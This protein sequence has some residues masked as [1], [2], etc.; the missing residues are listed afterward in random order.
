MNDRNTLL[1]T[2]ATGLVGAALRPRL[3]GD[4]LRV[5]TLGRD[6][7]RNDFVWDAASGEPPPAEALKGL[8]AVVNLAGSPIAER[9]SAA[10]KRDIRATRVN[11][12]L[13]LA[14]ALAALPVGDRPETF[15]SASGVSIYGIRRQE[16][17]LTEDSPL[18]PG[19]P[20]FLPAVSRDWEA[21]SDPAKQAGIRTVLLRMAP[22]LSAKGGMLRTVLPVFRAGLGGPVGDGRQRVCWIV[23]DDLVSLIRFALNTPTLA[24]PVNAVA[25]EIVTN[26]RFAELLGRAVGKRA[27]LR[28]PAGAVKLAFGEMAGETILSDVAPYPEKALRA[29][30]VFA[31]PT[32]EGALASLALK[33]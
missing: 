27:R 32:L 7:A 22:V 4:G 8:K 3:A 31:Y 2:G 25:P 26:E 19:S 17:R 16:T 29:G 12:T 24:G 30:F 10:R 6:P 14:S 21:A 18:I 15:V 5:V 23:L 11:G 9:W 1:L 28:T 13:A 20:Q 33:G